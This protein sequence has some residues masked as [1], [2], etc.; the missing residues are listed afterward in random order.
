[1]IDEVDDHRRPTLR[2]DGRW[3]NRHRRG[4]ARI[5]VP[6]TPKEAHG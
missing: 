3:N 6:M 2:T 1:V 5:L 4:V